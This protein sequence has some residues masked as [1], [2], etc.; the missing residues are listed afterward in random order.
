MAVTFTAITQHSPIVKNAKIV[1]EPSVYNGTGTEV[2]RN[3][4]LAVDQT[5]RDQIA[6]IETQMNLGPTLCSVLKPETVRVKV[7]M[8]N[9]RIFDSDHHQINLAEK[10]VHAN[11]EARLEVRGIWRTATN[12]GI[13]VCCTDLRFCSDNTVSP[14][15]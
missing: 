7:D 12:Y 10:W 13:S 14:F 4:V 2:R 15:K 8:Y 11:V 6:N 5:T 1:D 3:L 9:I